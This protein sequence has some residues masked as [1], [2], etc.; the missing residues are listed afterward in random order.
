MRFFLLSYGNMCVYGSKSRFV[1]VFFE[2]KDVCTG[3]DYPCSQ[4]PSRF[5]ESRLL[6]WIVHNACKSD[7]LDIFPLGP[8]STCI[9]TVTTQ[10]SHYFVKYCVRSGWLNYCPIIAYKALIKCPYHFSHNYAQHK[11]TAA[12][13]VIE[14]RASWKKFDHRPVPPKDGYQVI[15][16]FLIMQIRVKQILQNAKSGK[17]KDSAS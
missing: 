8:I 2:K 10:I 11:T 14:F 15:S 16:D 13:S 5:Y 12:R 6:T 1:T 17:F 7:I 3:P 4:W 9:S